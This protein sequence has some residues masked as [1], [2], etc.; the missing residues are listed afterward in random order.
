MLANTS[1]LA[2][3]GLC[4][5]E[6]A[7]AA[8]GRLKRCR[9]SCVD[10]FRVARILLL[11]R[12]G[13]VQS[14]VRPVDA[15]FR[16][17]GLDGFRG[18]GPILLCGLPC[19][20]TALHTL[21]RTR[22]WSSSIRRGNMVGIRLTVCWGKISKNLFIALL[23]LRCPTLERPANCWRSTLGA[24]ATFSHP[25]IPL[26]YQCGGTRPNSVTYA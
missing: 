18:S 15:V 4:H 23:A 9:M 19:G 26:P 16:T 8:V 5:I 6:H 1:S 13:R 17:A 11:W 2:S 7:R 12:F 14:C 22:L 10:G 3:R 20:S 25:F 24:R 21:S